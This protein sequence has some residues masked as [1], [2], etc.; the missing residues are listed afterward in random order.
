MNFKP[1]VVTLLLLSLAAAAPSQA[2]SGPRSEHPHKKG[3]SAGGEMASGAGD[4]GKGAAKGAG[5]LATG[6]GKG[7][8]DLVTLHPIDAAADV[9]K[10]GV[11]AGTHIA[12]GTTK[13]TFKVAKGVGK[14]VKH[15]F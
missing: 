6:A 1:G 15:I 10:G 3:R 11:S 5:S 14:G 12:V 7:A 8:V 9:G 2:A 4:I 13:G